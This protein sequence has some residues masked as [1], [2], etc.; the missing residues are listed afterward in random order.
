VA[1]MLR[2]RFTTQPALRAKSKN[3]QNRQRRPLHVRE[4]AAKT[5]KILQPCPL[6]TTAKIGKIG[7]SAPTALAGLPVAFMLRPSL[8]THPALRANRQNRQLLQWGRHSC[9]PAYENRPLRPLRPSRH[10]CPTAVLRPCMAESGARMLCSGHVWP[11]WPLDNP[12]GNPTY[13]SECG[14]EDEWQ[15]GVTA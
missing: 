15:P 13:S 4:I 5:A 2:S 12:P 6:I 1:F 7:N 3:R 11:R 9:L 14:V 8:I 10:S